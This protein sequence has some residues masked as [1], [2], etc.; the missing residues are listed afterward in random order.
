LGEITVRNTFRGGR[1]NIH[2]GHEA[3][4]CR[5]ISYKEREKIWRDAVEREK[6]TRKPG[7][8]NGELGKAG[9]A[10]LHCLLFDFMNMKTGVCFPRV[11]TLQGVTTR[12]CSDCTTS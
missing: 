9:L 10:V 6:A 5:S 12:K 2:A 8:Q 3:A 7:C 1:R 11:R 4:N